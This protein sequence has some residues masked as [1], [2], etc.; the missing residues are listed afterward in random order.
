MP[1][2][3]NMLA[4]IPFIF[5]N[6]LIAAVM[7]FVIA[8]AFY[9]GLAYLG[10]VLFGEDLPEAD[11]GPTADAQSRSWNPH[12][13][14]QEGIARPKAYGRNMHHGNIVANWTSV[15]SNREKLHMIVEHGDGPT[16]GIVYDGAVPQIFLNDQPIANFDD[17]DIQERLGTLNQTCMT[18]FEKTKLEYQQQGAELKKDEPIIVTTPNDYFDDLE[19]TILWP[20]GLY[21]WGSEGKKRKLGYCR[22]KV[23]IREHPDGGW[24]EISNVNYQLKVIHPLFLLR[25]VSALWDHVERGKQYDLEFTNLTGPLTRHTNNVYL[26]S[27]REVIDIAFTRPGK[28]LVGIRAV[29]TSQLSGRLDVKVIREDKLVRV[30]NGSTWSIEHSRNRAWVVYDVFTQPVISG[31]GNGGGPFTV[32][33]YEGMDPARLDLDF[34][35]AWAEFCSGSVPDGYGGNEDRIACDTILDFQTD[36]WTFANEIANI[37]RA[38]LYWQGHTLTGWIDKVETSITDLVTMNNIMARTWKNAWSEKNTLAGKVEVFF[39]DSRQG[40]ERTSAPLP[41]ESAG[42]YTKIISIEGVGITTR[43]TAIHLA[44]H[45]LLRNQLI[46]NVN[47][48]RQYKDA[49]R[50]H[51]GDVIRLQHKIPDW[52]VGY[53]VLEST[54]ANKVTLDRTCTADPGDTL[55]VRS[56]N[57]VLEIVVTDDYIVQSVADKVVTITTAWDVA[58]IKNNLCAIGPAG[59]IQL[60]RI[61]KIESAVTNYFDVTVETYDPQLFDADDLVPD[62]PD[63]NYIWAQPANP[64]TRPVT[65][66]E[67]I[68]LIGQLVPPPANVDS[69][70]TSNCTWTG[71]GGDTVTWAATDA[72]EPII[73]SY[74][75]ESYEIDPDSTTDEFVYWHPAYPTIFSHTDDA[76]VAVAL[77]RWMM[78]RNVAGVVW[79]TIPFSSIHAG[80]L[81]AGSIT[82]AYGQ[83]G[84]LAVETLYINDLAV[85]TIK[86]ADFAISREVAEYA[87]SKVYLMAA[88]TTIC[89]PISLQVAYGDVKLTVTTFYGTDPGDDDFWCFFREDGASI[90]LSTASV[91]VLAAWPYCMCYTKEYRYTPGPGTYEYTVVGFSTNTDAWVLHRFFTVQEMKK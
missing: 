38:H 16:K 72:T 3:Y 9:Y 67:V 11:T 53:R 91:T 22:I 78:C 18:G 88:G 7:N 54:A 33:Y 83:I 52:G 13:T 59:S 34:F 56:Y 69:P 74:K 62:N 23:R 14:Q 2:E 41:N 79:P 60:R 8:V 44:N 87:T 57:T 89:G 48:F 27:F 49:F 43:G 21:R 42:R 19:Y 24:T 77:G 65:R 35:Y 81:Q 75:G 70:V 63:Q 32:E 10:G 12:T 55:Y 30:W 1:L 86:V 26:K 37:G 47:N 31:D 5:T 4:I 46:R 29:A 66:G 39:Q 40:Y 76:A 17:V 15:V 73:F 51:L 28:A 25:T 61:I 6:W 45:A 20:N 64:L 58:P 82:A 90:E 71:S 84:A 36:V 50:Y 68:E 85:T 80:V